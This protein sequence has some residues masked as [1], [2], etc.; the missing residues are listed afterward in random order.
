MFWCHMYALKAL[1]LSLSSQREAKG[2]YCSFFS[3]HN[4]RVQAEE[5][6]CVYYLGEFLG[7]LQHLTDPL[8]ILQQTWFVTVT[9]TKVSK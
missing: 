5:G 3:I 1:F 7:L 8:V 9:R 4:D 2:T 6:I